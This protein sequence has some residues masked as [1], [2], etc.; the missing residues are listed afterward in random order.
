MPDVLLSNDD[1]TVLGP[2][3]TVEVLVD[4]GPTGT[5]G[6]KVFVGSGNP[7]NLTSSGSIFGQAIILNDLYINISPGTNYGYMYQYVSEPGGN[8]WV[9]ILALNPTIYSKLHTTT[10]VNGEASITIPISDIVTV[11]GSP[12]TANN[13]VVQYSIS[14]THAVASTVT[15]P[16]LVGDG[17]NLVLNFKAVEYH[18]ESGPTEWIDLDE[19]VITH[20]LISVVESEES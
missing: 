3:N 18:P 7:N 16:A 12:L 11:T 14:H 13:F 15:V 2:P 17:S 9:E 6:S 5:R 19:E 8:T 1:V 4:I 20:L 10:Y